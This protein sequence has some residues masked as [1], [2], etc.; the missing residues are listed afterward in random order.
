[1]AGELAANKL[2]KEAAGAEDQSEASKF[3]GVKDASFA[4]F[5][6]LVLFLRLDDRS[7]DSFHG[8][9]KIS[10]VEL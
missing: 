8:R 4:R 10:F 5:P 7:G 1:M 3:T 9:K 2:S 6:W